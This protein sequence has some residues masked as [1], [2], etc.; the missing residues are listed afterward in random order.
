M[1]GAGELADAPLLL[2]IGTLLLERGKWTDAEKCL[3]RSL[4]VSETAGA[5][6]KLADSQMEQ[7]AYEMALTSYKKAV[8]LA[9]EADGAPLAA[10][11]K[12]QARH[13]LIFHLG[14]PD[15]VED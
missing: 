10:H 3:Q 13:I 9:T 8:S 1:R 5:M 4:V 6:A 2:A 15:E 11:C 12:K 14:R 7:H